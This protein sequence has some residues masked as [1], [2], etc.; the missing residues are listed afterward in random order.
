VTALT[1]A[2]SVIPTHAS[3]WDTDS[4]TVE[5][6]GPFT[7]GEGLGWSVP[8]DHPAFEVG[9]GLYDFS[10]SKLVMFEDGVPLGRPHALHELV[11]RLGGG[12]HCHWGSTLFF[13]TSDGSD[14]NTNGRRYE[15]HYVD[16]LV[17]PNH[18]EL[19]ALRSRQEDAVREALTGESADL[20]R[21]LDD[22]LV[23]TRFS[24]EHSRT[25]ELCRL[26]MLF[27]EVL[28]LLELLSRL[29]T[30]QAVEIGSF[31]GAST[32]ALSR[33]ASRS[34]GRVI[35][36]DVG[37]EN[38]LSHRPS[39]DIHRDLSRNLAWFGADEP[40]TTLAGFGNAP[41]ILEQVAALLDGRPIDLLFI[42]ADGG[43]AR[44]MAI[45]GPWLRPG[46]MVIL[47]D[48][49]AEGVGKAAVV[50]QGVGEMTSSGR[51][52]FIGEYGT[53]WFGRVPLGGP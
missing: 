28:S 27:P 1:P 30:G 8:V 23:L 7:Q 36:I 26:A 19:E 40:V 51:L 9:D 32:I 5:V 44:D 4:P 35:S 38:R 41:L 13:S 37:G 48:F 42:D 50:R 25:R 31:V 24:V 12:L 3:F 29:V 15:L 11:R 6:C 16:E 53:T 49:G 47:D 10:V 45:Y 46:A 20:V 18:E 14:P 43:V 17:F 52:E 22:W 39:R 2:G 33:G 21:Q 34:G